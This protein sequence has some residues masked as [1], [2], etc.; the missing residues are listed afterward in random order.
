MSATELVAGLQD[1]SISS[2]E[3]LERYL[4]RIATYGPSLNAVVTVQSTAP[5]PRRTP[6]MTRRDAASLWGLS[7]A[8]Q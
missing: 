2:R 5:A 8:C 7:M 6:P 3:L 4:Q 1:G